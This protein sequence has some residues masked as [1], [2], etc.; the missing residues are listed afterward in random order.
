MSIVHLHLLLNHIPVVGA[1]F[2]VLLFGAALFLRETVSTKFALAFTA[3]I[4]AVAVAVYLTGGPAGEA[5]EKLAGVTERG[6]E[7]HEE[8]AE[9]AT[10]AFSILGGLSLIA[11]IV[12]RATR[13][14]RWIAFAG[15]VGSLA[16]SGLMGWTANLGG[17]IRHSE[18]QSPSNQPAGNEVED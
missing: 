1:L 12:F 11:L 8:A 9:L 15:L 4:A 7:Q 6:I 14:P 16:I 5:V 13:A 17:R 2:A 3:A 18:I 10:V